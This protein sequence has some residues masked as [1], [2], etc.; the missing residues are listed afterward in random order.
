[1]GTA[2]SEELPNGEDSSFAAG[3]EGEDL[4][5]LGRLARG[6]HARRADGHAGNGETGDARALGEET[7]DEIG[8][9]VAF[10]HVAVDQRGVTGAELERD[11]VTALD[12]AHVA[13]RLVI[14][15]KATRA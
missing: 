12:R 2:P 1:M 10:D 13:H 11:T 14:D 4:V 15:G 3:I 6:F 8:R 9:D 7:I 5:A